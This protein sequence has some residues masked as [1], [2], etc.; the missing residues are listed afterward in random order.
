M[1]SSVENDGTS[2]RTLAFPV[3]VMQHGATHRV[4][5]YQLHLLIIKLVIES[6]T[7][8]ISF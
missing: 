3:L 6:E 8:K 5:T 4:L 2:L 7:V 1:I